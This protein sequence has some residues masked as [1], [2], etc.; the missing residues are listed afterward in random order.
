MSIKIIETSLRDGQQS[1]AATRMTTKDILSVVSDMDQAG[2]Y[3][4]EVWGGATFD[5]CLRYLHEDPWERLRLIRAQVKHT[6]LQMLLRGQNLV[7]YKPYPDEVVDLFIKKAI[8]NG[9]D[10]IRI[11]DALN[12]MNN[13]KSSLKATKAY[14]AHA[15]VA[16]SYTKSPVHNI[17]YYV[18]LAVEAEQLGADSIAIKDMAGLLLP[19]DA[20]DLI[21]SIK[22][23]IKIPLNLHGHDTS[24]LI[25]ATYIKAIEAGIDMIDTALSPF[26]GGTSQP[27]TEGIVSIL[28]NMHISHDI[29]LDTLKDAIKTLEHVRDDLIKKGHY[30]MSSQFSHPNIFLSQVPGGMYSNLVSQLKEQQLIH[31]LDEVLEEIPKVRK[32]LGYPPL[33]TPMSQIVGV[34]ATLNVV[35][36]ERYKILTSE[37]I[38]YAKGA[39]GQPPFDMDDTILALIK[40]SDKDIKKNHQPKTLHDLK[41]TYQKTT[42]QDEEL[43][44]IMLMGDIAEKFYLEKWADNNTFQLESHFMLKQNYFKYRFHVLESKSME[45]FD[46]YAPFQGQIESILV[47]TSHHVLMDEPIIIMKVN[48]LFIELLSPC[49]GTIEKIQVEINQHVLEKEILLIVK[50]F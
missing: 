39:Y 30:D 3:A 34:Q 20:Y 33:V 32:D 35:T 44:S 21:T 36:N 11:F 38:M 8:D 26:A 7:G 23:H 14:G 18:N 31:R 40:R 42:F 37:V 41:E 1:L 28:H 29:K 19:Q 27:S 13:I 24:G 17:P 45:D 6:K 4:L 49:N 15:Q 48:H 25:S 10:I 46:M 47:K 2:F 22:S 12:D 50:P 5:A 16:L 43:L 9:I